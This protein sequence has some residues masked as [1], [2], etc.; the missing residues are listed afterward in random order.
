MRAILALAVL[1]LTVPAAWCGDQDDLAARCSRAYQKEELDFLFQNCPFDT[2]MLARSQCERGDETV[3]EKY[4]DFCR[5]F[6]NGQAPHYG[7][8][9]FELPGR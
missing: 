6:K 5:K 2:W 7:P 3:T 9:G 8:N 4:K 1:A